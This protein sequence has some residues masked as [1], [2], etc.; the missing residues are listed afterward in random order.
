MLLILFQIILFIILLTLFFGILCTVTGE[1]N[2]GNMIIVNSLTVTILCWIILNLFNSGENL[3]GIFKSGLPLVENVERVG[4]LG[5]YL[6]DSPGNFAMDF[7]ELVVLIILISWVSN[8]FSFENAGIVSKLVSRIGIV[9]VGIILYGITMDMIGE[10]VVI[11][12]LVYCVEC[13]ITGGSLLYTPIRFWAFITGLKTNNIALLFL[14]EQF[15]KTAIGK[16]I[17]SA[18]TSAIMLICFFLVLEK[19]YG[20]ICTVLDGTINV[21]EVMGGAVII[22]MGLYFVLKSLNVRSVGSHG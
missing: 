8:L 19:Q 10:N 6:K 3:G 7:V 17:H 2:K 22:I 18:I 20:S 9:L 1:K 11:K 13:I 14:L 16:A 5:L 12:W 21:M 15:P 4:N